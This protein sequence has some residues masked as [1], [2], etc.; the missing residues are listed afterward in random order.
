MCPSVSSYI[1]SYRVARILM[2]AMCVVIVM[3]AIVMVA[4]CSAK[5]HSHIHQIHRCGRH[6][7]YDW[8]DCSIIYTMHWL[9]SIGTMWSA[10]RA[11]GKPATCQRI[12]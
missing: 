7:R 6:V 4:T 12:V 8:V 2:V 9:G 10:F 5:E 1:A 11:S 3:V